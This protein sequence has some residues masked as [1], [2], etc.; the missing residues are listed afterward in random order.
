MAGEGH[1]RE[2]DKMAMPFHRRLPI[3]EIVDSAMPCTS[4]NGSF[5]PRCSGTA[6]GSHRRPDMTVRRGDAERRFDTH[7]LYAENLKISRLLTWMAC[8]RP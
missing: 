3:H 7:K 6:G 2:A 5:P 1:K 8:S 4:G